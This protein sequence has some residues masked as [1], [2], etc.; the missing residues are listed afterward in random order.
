VS[1]EH[2]SQKADQH[3]RQKE[4][5]FSEP[6]M[7]APELDSLGRQGTFSI[8]TMQR[9]VGNRAVQ[10]MLDDG[11]LQRV[12]A[13]R[14]RLPSLLQR[15]P[16]DG[17]VPIA[18]A[19]TT[20]DASTSDTTAPPPNPEFDRI[21]HTVQFANGGDRFD[22]EYEPNNGN[23]P[24]Q[25]PIAGTLR[26]ILKLHINFRNFTR[27]IRRQEP[28]NTMRFTPQQR[29]DFNWTDPER[30][31][32]RRNIIPSIHD[33]WSGKHR[34]T[35]NTPG[36]EELNAGI[37]VQVRLVDTADEAHTKITAQKV[38]EGAPRFRSFVQGDEATLDRL[39]PT[40]A[41]THNIDTLHRTIEPFDH[42]SADLTPVQ[43]QIDDFIR[44]F[45][46]LDPQGDDFAD[47][48]TLRAVGR[49]TTP[50]SKAHNTR[51]ARQRA[52]NVSDYI[53]TNSSRG[54]FS[55]NTSAEGET[56][57]TED[58]EFRRVDLYLT[59][60]ADTEQMV[61]AHEAG[62]MFGLGDEYEDVEDDDDPSG[63]GRFTGDR[64]SHYEDAVDEL[65]TPA[66]DE[67]LVGNTD[68]MM[69]TGMEVAPAHYTPFIQA[70]ELATGIQW[71]INP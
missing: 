56:G 51:L 13:S 53:F 70:I 30:E 12:A 27:E 31:E 40:E 22:I 52:D 66:A 37:D 65:G 34:L 35:S 50:G 69:S 47:Q 17:G 49:A 10:R 2:A 4:L 39:D 16:N 71:T 19:P 28:Y 48:F 38:P 61:A 64:P 33:A 43:S 45:D 20:D 14:L 68:S 54:S 26:I 23:G 46:A 58:E 6:D 8:E 15:D 55:M 63:R 18:G 59:Q 7:A 5:P 21:I 1:D 36:C 9:L 42:D 32:F 24:D 57:T 67:V 44:E 3:K 29:R 60:K 25:R 11:A 62:H 41:E